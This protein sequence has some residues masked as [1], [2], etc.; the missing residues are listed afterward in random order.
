M[1]DALHEA[2]DLIFTAYIVPAL[3]VPFV[4]MTLRVQRALSGHTKQP[5]AALAGLER[6][7]AVFV[8]AWFGLWLASRIG[9][10]LER[11]GRPLLLLS[12]IG[13]AGLNLVFAALMIRFTSDY[14]DVP[15]GREKDLLFL[16]FLGLVMLQPVTTACA[17]VVLYQA[18]GVAYRLYMPALPIL[19]LGI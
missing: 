16:R 12:W 4:W 3:L 8:A 13:F 18:M 15:D 11:A 7:Y 5:A 14:G 9:L 10:P 19:P 6:F 17:F 2:T 1:V